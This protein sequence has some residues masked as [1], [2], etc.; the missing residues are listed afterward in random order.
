MKIKQIEENLC[1]QLNQKIQEKYKNKKI[2]KEDSL[3]CL[4]LAQIYFYQSKISKFLKSKGNNQFV[5]FKMKKKSIKNIK[6]SKM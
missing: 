3:N 5:L 2:N 4:I 1:N 6:I